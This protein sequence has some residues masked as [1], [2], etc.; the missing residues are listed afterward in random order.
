MK[1][2][3]ARIALALA[4]A[5]GTTAAVTVYTQ[6]ALADGGSTGGIDGK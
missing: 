5:I 1:H 3:I 6:P 4:L 2:L